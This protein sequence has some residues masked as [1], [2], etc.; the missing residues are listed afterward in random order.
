MPRISRTRRYA[1]LAAAA[2]AGA[3]G[4]LVHPGA[5]AV[6]DPAP[7]GT[8]VAESVRTPGAAAS[9]PVTLTYDAGAAAEFTDSVA[10]AVATWTAS[11]DNVDLRP[12]E[13]GRTTDIRF[14][15]FD[16]WPHAEQGTPGQGTAYIGREAVTEGYDPARITTHE[17]GHLLG[18]DDVKPGPCTS[19]TSESTAGT[20]CHNLSPNEA[21]RSAIERIFG[22]LQPGTGPA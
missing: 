20:S 4:A 1:L 22:A 9:R 10:T 19:L 18:L 16:G 3:A 11:L 2:A 7:H 17:L 14:V 5:F 8:T 15:A 13:P 6:A 12:V 21:E